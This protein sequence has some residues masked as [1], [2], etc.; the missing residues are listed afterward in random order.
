M[1]RNNKLHK[2]AFTLIELIFAIVVIAV[3][4]MSL[5]MMKEINTTA[6]ERNLVQ[7]AIFATVAEINMATTY[8]W[9][10]NSFLDDNE[11]GTGFD[12][13]SRVV[14][15]NGVNDCADN[16]TYFQ[17]PGHI[18]RQCINNEDI[19]MYDL[20][21]GNLVN[22]LE[23]SVHD[24]N[25]TYDVGGETSAEGYKKKYESKLNV[26]YCGD[27]NCVQFG[28]ETNN[29][30][31][32]EITVSIRDEETEETLTLLRTYSANI[33]EVTYASKDL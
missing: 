24:W 33:G 13:L 20:S 30:N 15:T 19:E 17:R 5:P 21:L 7:E 16:G 4:V 26:I 1:V 10:E 11:S 28:D 2:K 8:V 12:D 27:G 32:K 14:Y 22:S 29:P 6:M 3:S 31:L 9:D 18:S 23:T 25:T